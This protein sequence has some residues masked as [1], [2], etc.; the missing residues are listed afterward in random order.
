MSADGSNPTI[1][2][3]RSDT[4]FFDVDADW[5]PLLAPSTQ[6]PP[7]VLG[8]SSAN[9]QA[10]EDAGSVTVTVTR[11]GNL[12]EA[13][14]FFYATDLLRPTDGI[15]ADVQHDYLPVYGALNFAPGETSKT[16]LIPLTDNGDVRGNRFFKI[17]LYDNDG[18]ATFLGGIREATITKLDRD[19]VPRAVNPIDNARYFVRQHYVD[20]LNRE[21]DP[22]GWD[23]WTNQIT[24]CNG[25]ASC[26]DIKQQNVSA[27]FFLSTEFQETGYFFLRAYFL[28]LDLNYG[29]FF[30]FERAL[31]QLNRG[32]IVRQPGWQ[33]QLEKNK[34][35]FI[36]QN[37]NDGRV[38]T[39]FGRTNEQYVGLLFQ[40]AGLTPLLSERDPLVN[41]LNQGTLTRAQVLRLVADNESNHQ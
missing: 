33:D 10:Y 17:A 19:T 39:S 36:Q 6:L 27:A 40:Y 30:G 28:G 38:S 21:P 16:I 8:F 18:N 4:S 32:V 24:S 25:D 9:Y 11:T 35:A 2:S 5:Q 31:Q 20:F 34:Q 22:S 15:T 13:V 7:A 12:N 26:T 37:F 29:G 14:S 3:Y 23:F 1:L 41:G